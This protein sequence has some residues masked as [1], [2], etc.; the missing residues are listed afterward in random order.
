[1]KK[2]LAAG[3]AA[4]LLALIPLCLLG[5]MALLALFFALGSAVPLLGQW[6]PLQAAGIFAGTAFLLLCVPV[7]AGA[8]ICGIASLCLFKGQTPGAWR[9]VAVLDIALGALVAVP[10]LFLLL[11]A[12]SGQV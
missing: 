1:M 2:N 4:R 7:P 6:E 11:A 9:A 5:L 8:V 12:V 10:C 3:K